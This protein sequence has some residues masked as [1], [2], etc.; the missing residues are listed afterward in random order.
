MLS[1]KR[2]LTA[3]VSVQCRQNNTAEVLR[4]QKTK[5]Q[6]TLIIKTLHLRV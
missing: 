2:D 5:S 3:N 4:K 1:T 6:L